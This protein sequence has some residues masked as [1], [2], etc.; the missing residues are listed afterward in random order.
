MKPNQA[1]IIL[2]F[3]ENYRFVIEDAIQGFHW[4]NSQATLYQFVVYY[5]VSD[6]QLC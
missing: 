2:G 5:K 1:I 3:A 4:N 6:I